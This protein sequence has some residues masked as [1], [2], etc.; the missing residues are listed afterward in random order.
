VR[1]HARTAGVGDVGSKLCFLLIDWVPLFA[2]LLLVSIKHH[3]ARTCHNTQ[4]RADAENDL[5]FTRVNSKNAHT[6]IRV[7]AATVVRLHHHRLT[8]PYIRK[9]ASQSKAKHGVGCHT[10][11][12]QFLL[13]VIK[14]LQAQG[15]E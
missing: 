8:N 12:V 1:K 7:T 15:Y 3:H 5:E 13:C 6:T 9:L 14:R 10:D 4:S 2:L 11:V